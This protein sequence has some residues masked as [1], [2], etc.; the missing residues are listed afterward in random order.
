M[1]VIERLKPRL[2][3]IPTFFAVYLFCADGFVWLV[4]FLGNLCGF[5]SYGIAQEKRGSGVGK[6]L[7]FI[8][9]YYYYF[10]RKVS[11]CSLCG[12]FENRG[13]PGGLCQAL[14]APPPSPLP[15]PFSEPPSQKK[16]HKLH[17]LLSKRR[18]CFVNQA[19]TRKKFCA[20]LLFWPHK[21][22]QSRTETRTK[23]HKALCVARVAFKCAAESGARSQT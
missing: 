9:N 2:P 21:T 11:L 12:F 6:L 14:A 13:F 15:T 16:P 19:L 4:R 17:K 8:E 5:G 23:P 1:N 18:F 22:A 20:V 10:I 3:Q 7:F